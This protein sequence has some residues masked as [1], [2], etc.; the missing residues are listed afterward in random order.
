MRVGRVLPPAAAVVRLNDLLAGLAGLVAP[1]QAIRTLEH[2][3]RNHFGARHV[4][5]VSSG[6][7]ALV[8]ALRALRTR[9]KRNE[10]VVPAYTCFSVPA[11]VMH[12]GLRP[13]PCDI[14]PETFDF[15]R[16][17]LEGSLNDRTLAVIGHHLFGIPSDIDAT[18]ALCAPRD[19]VVIEDAAQAMG[20]ATRDGRLLGTLGDIG[21]FS[22]GRGKN[23][24]SG[25]GGILLVAS[26]GIAAAIRTE[27]ARLRS[28]STTEALKE[29]MKVAAMA[30]FV[31]PE[32]YWLP[33]SVPALGLGQTI[34][35]THVRTQRMSGAQAGLLRNWRRRLADSNRLRCR[36]AADLQDRSGRHVGPATTTYLRLPMMADSRA[37]R[38]RLLRESERRGLGF[39]RAYPTAISDIPELRPFLD[40]RGYPAAQRVADR[41]FTVPTHP[42]VTEKDRRAI[43]DCLRTALRPVRPAA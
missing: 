1:T 17:L 42:Y 9:S 7:A 37:E 40:C 19:V 36:T 30:A 35:P 41:I 38:D 11:A 31:R 34:F 21:V 14:E 5:L 29:L 28:V 27:A 15:N 6:T 24:T 25:S 43:A 12:A 33:A 18:R 22:A 4:C 13:V 26:D 2:E 23:I 39:S 8:V 16:R 20:G 32:A 10:V 3:L